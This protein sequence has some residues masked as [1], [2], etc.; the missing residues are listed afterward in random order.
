M[1]SA[2]ASVTVAV[3]SVTLSSSGR[4]SCSVTPHRSDSTHIVRLAGTHPTETEMPPFG[5]SVRMV[6]GVQEA[7]GSIEWF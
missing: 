2:V 3:N 6:V 7:T 4:Y 5:Q 1:Y